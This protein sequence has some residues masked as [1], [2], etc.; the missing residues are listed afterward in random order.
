MEAEQ[1]REREVAEAEIQTQARERERIFR[2]IHDGLG[3]NIVEI[4]AMSEQLYA[5]LS[6]PKNSEEQQSQ[7]NAIWRGATDLRVGLR[8]IVWLL[9]M[10]NDT[11][12][13]LLA[14][15]RQE[16]HRLTDAAALNFHVEIITPPETPAPQNILIAPDLRRNIVMAVREAT[17]NI[18]KHAG[19]REVWLKMIFENN[20]LTV[21]LRDDGKGFDESEI[22]RFSNGLK[23]M[24]KRMNACGGR[25]EIESAVNNGTT[26]RFVMPI[27]TGK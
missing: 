20:T 10:E 22:G 2:D 7:A 25:F 9:N 17:G 16:V 19:A 21:S 23:T 6:L 26:V 14:Y 4:A 18:I 11:L 8:E 15:L 12:E 1:Q 27:F 24:Q 13:A 3:A 5:E